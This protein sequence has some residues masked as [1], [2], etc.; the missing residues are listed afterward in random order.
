MNVV[1]HAALGALLTA[2]CVA[3]VAGSQSAVPDQRIAETATLRVGTPTVVEAPS[4]KARF[5]VVFEDDGETGY[6]YA[7]DP[8]RGEQPILDALHIYNVESVADRDRPSTLQIAWS[9]S[10][11]HAALLINSYP[12]AVFDFADKRGYCRTGFPPPDGKWTS[13]S[14]EW[15]DAALSFFR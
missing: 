11:E 2:C 5:V 15:Q 4:P 7:V 8:S 1:R 3:N 12:H 13:H 6:F 9:A 14:H 10:G